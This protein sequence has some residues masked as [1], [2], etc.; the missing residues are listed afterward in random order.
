M[1]GLVLHNISL[2]SHNFQFI[3]APLYATG[4]KQ[5]NGIGHISYT[6]R[7][8]KHFRAIELGLT[9]ARFSTLDGTDSNGVKVFGGFHKLVP[10]LRFTFKNRSL[11]STVE[12]WIEWKTYLIGEKRFNYVMDSDDS[13]TYPTPGATRD[14]YLN[15]LTFTITD[16]RKLYPYD[17]QLQLQ[18]GMAFTGPMPQVII[19]SIMLMAVGCR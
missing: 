10:S 17:V 9:G 8:N 16:Y 7:P 2:P 14:R 18:Q 4:S 13:M 15:Q 12:K 11:L 6:W 5:L 1:V 3:L 19:S